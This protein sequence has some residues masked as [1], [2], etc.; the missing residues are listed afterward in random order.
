MTAPVVRSLLLPLLLLAGLLFGTVAPLQ[1]AGIDSFI[2]TYQEIEGYLPPNSLPI[3][4]QE[5][6]AAKS[7][8]TCLE[9][10][11]D[12]GRCI[13]D[14]SN[15]PL[16]QQVVQ[17]SG[18][19]SSFWSVLDAYVAYRSGDVWGVVYNL[20]EAAACAV[21]Q[22]LAGGADICGFIEELV[23]IAASLWDTA[24]AVAEFFSELGEGVWE[25]AKSAYCDTLGGLFGGCDEGGNSPPE[26]VAYAWVFAPRLAEGLAAR[27]AVDPQA[28][29]T[30]R[31]QLIT[32]ASADPAQFNIPLPD[33]VQITFTPAAVTTA[34]GI[35]TRTV[36]QNWS[37]EITS[38]VLPALSKKRSEYATPAQIGYLASQATAAFKSSGADL[39][40]TIARRCS[41]D[42]LLTY[43]FAHVDRWI[44]Y[45][46]TAAAAAKVQAVPTSTW[47][48]G[49]FIAA[50]RQEFAK[51]FRT[52]VKTAYCPEFGSTLLCPSVDAHEKCVKVLGSVG[53][54]GQCGINTATAARE[55]AE[56]VVQA[57]K[58][59]GSKGSYV[60][61]APA[62]PVSSAPAELVC[63][64]PPQQHACAEEAVKRFG[65]Y[66]VKMVNCTVKEPPEY[67]AL[68]EAVVRAV[69]TLNG[70]GR[71]IGRSGMRT[72]GAEPVTKDY[73]IDA[74]DPL[75]VHATSGEA[76]KRAMNEK[77]S[78]G[79]KAPSTQPGFAFLLA[80][81]GTS[82]DGFDTPTITGD[83]DLNPRP[84]L[85]T[86][87]FKGKLDPRQGV[88][89]VDRSRMLEGADT[90]VPTVTT[91]ISATEAA[92]RG[93]AASPAKALPSVSPAAPSGQQ[94]V[95]SGTFPPQSDKPS[96]QTPPRGVV[97]PGRPAPPV[98]SVARSS[99]APLPD[100]LADP[101]PLVAGK[102]AQ[103]GAVIQLDA[104]E[105]VSRSKGVCQIPVRF[106]VRNGGNASS[107][108]FTTVW[109]STLLPGSVAS[110]LWAPLPAGASLART[111]TLGLKPG[112]NQLILIIDGAAQVRESNE[113]NNRLNLT[114]TLTGLCDD[115][116]STAPMKPAAPL[117]PAGRG[118]R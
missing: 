21:L 87:G 23:A 59:R 90:N 22:V 94:K 48:S 68:K 101:G 27:M 60:I 80:V 55:A 85:A 106:T 44:T 58:N 30:V 36:D 16:G 4:S 37:A 116:P 113:E 12:V 112:T 91:G 82:I 63:Q 76:L 51:R 107:G 105:T 84:P 57:L 86:D 115:T 35:Y 95:M 46:G 18:L 118:R 20:G 66:P 72:G 92:V 73:L 3:S 65:S 83:V 8:F 108:G 43:G 17:E 5:L 71:L 33:F 117:P 79:F 47:C 110:H 98:P 74:V 104:R 39:I 103:W 75:H 25:A 41:D 45:P 14:F 29:T 100:L 99:G 38:H 81:Q 89:P 32:Q 9:G 70:E 6:I 78:F 102:P 31:E 19:P 97:E 54:Q 56:L 28:F 53:E 96:L 26:A 93:M 15:T 69:A 52:F 67:A 64:R 61:V 7:L 111:E 10:G 40:Q 11:G 114:I 13:N 2:S 50:N 24:T 42:F 62:G 34:A 88:D 49:S 77:R 1:A 109:T